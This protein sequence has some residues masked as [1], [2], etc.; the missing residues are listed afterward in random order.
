MVSR[1][2]LPGGTRRLGRRG[3]LLVSL[4]GS[5]A[6]V[7]LLPAAM[8]LLRVDDPDAA[9]SVDASRLRLTA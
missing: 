4:A 8:R 5:T 2:L 1:I 9:A 7:A 6:A 3:L